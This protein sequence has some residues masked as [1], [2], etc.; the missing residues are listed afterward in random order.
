[1]LKKMMKHKKEFSAVL[2]LCLIAV[3]VNA[4]GETDAWFTDSQV[5]NQAIKVGN[6]KLGLTREIHDIFVNQQL[7]PGATYNFFSEVQNLGSLDGQLRVKI[8]PIF[9][10]ED[11]FAPN[12]FYESGL[13]TDNVIFN[14]TPQ[15]L[16]KFTFN[17]DDG[18]YYLNDTFYSNQS[19]L[20]FEGVTLD[21]ELTGNEYNVLDKNLYLSYQVIAEIR[22]IPSSIRSGEGEITYNIPDDAPWDALISEPT[23]NGQPIHSEA[24]EL[25]IVV[26]SIKRVGNQIIATFDR[27][28]ETLEKFLVIGS[29]GEM[30]IIEDVLFTGNNIICNISEEALLPENL[31]KTYNVYVRELISMQILKEVQ[32]TIE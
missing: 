1:M 6:M 8:T 19:E 21:G 13:P 23:I 7:E 22:Q 29:T 14:F 12:Y 30:A 2:L 31:G 25:D 28:I 18:Y 3:F 5:T 27:D 10:F 20:L 16:G 4:S 15:F 17:E 24:L 26:E 32:I 11:A 9:A